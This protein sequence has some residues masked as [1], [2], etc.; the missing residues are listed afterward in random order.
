METKI[1][2]QVLKPGRVLHFIF[3]LSCGQSQNLVFVFV[4]AFIEKIL[5]QGAIFTLKHDISDASV[6]CI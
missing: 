3:C 2:A 4:G 1:A 6:G 5:L